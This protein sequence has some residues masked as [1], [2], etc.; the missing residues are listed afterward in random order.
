MFQFLSLQM[1]KMTRLS[2]RKSGDRER[3]LM[4]D[5]F[6]ADG[7]CAITQSV[8]GASH[9]NSG[10]PNQD[11]IAVRR[12][13]A[14]LIVAI[15][16]GHG[17]SRYV[18]SDI[19][20]RLAVETAVQELHPF[21][22]GTAG[23]IFSKNELESRIPMLLARK[24]DQAVATDLE[25]SPLR[26][27]ERCKSGVEVGEERSCYGAT[28]IVIVATKTLLLYVHLGDGDI[29]EVDRRGNVFRPLTKDASLIGN[30][31]TSLCSPEP[32]KSMRMVSRV[33]DSDNK[34][35][36]PSLILAATDGYANCFRD[37]TSFLKAGKDF[38]ELLS[39]PDGVEVVQEHLHGW[40]RESSDKYSGDDISVALVCRPV[41]RKTKRIQKG[42]E[43]NG[44]A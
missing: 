19:G 43:A 36:Q 37:E 41:G 24:W 32:W 16:D 4:P 12:G 42:G 18:R 33:L 35:D 20:A 22:A 27:E 1:T 39:R 28:L 21:A 26:A 23:R 9:F 5:V 30:E 15:S 29:V 25:G 10:L 8:K 31:T 44:T 2:R 14:G 7:W 38:H 40:L 17:G 13:K 6:R 3:R 34:D 11:A